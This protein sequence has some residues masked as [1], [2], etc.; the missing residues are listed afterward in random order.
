[1]LLS[2]AADGVLPGPPPPARL[3]A[4]CRDVDPVVPAGVPM[5]AEARFQLFRPS[6]LQSDGT[7]PDG[8]RGSDHWLWNREPLAAVPRVDGERVVL[9][10]EPAY[11]LTWEIDR[12]FPQ[13][14]ADLDLVDVLSPFAV[15]HHLRKLGGAPAPMPASRPAVPARAA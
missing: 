13:L 10:G 12:R 14:A 1:V 6:G 9:L 15:A 8:F 11:R 3:R 4:A 7:L 2:D 5:I